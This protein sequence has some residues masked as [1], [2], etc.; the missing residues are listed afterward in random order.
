MGKMPITTEDTV[1]LNNKMGFAE[2]LEI[3]WEIY[4]L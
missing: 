2:F 1:C 4:V 3:E